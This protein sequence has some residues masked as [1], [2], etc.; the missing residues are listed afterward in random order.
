MDKQRI[1]DAMLIKA[2]RK[3]IRM[4][5]LERWLKPYQIKLAE[6]N[7]MRVPKYIWWPGRVQEMVGRYMK[8]L[9]D[10]LWDTDKS[11][12]IDT[13]N[14]MKNLQCD[15]PYRKWDIERRNLQ[16]QSNHDRRRGGVF[17]EAL[18]AQRRNNQWN[19]TK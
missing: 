3:D 8:P 14:W 7:L 13:L 17:T 18:D 11:K 6:D 12:D 9:A 5:D 15:K 16:K 10:R 4:T 2:F 19:V 1:Y